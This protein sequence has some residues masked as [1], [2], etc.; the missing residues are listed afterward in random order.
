MASVPTSKIAGMVF[1]KL[2]ADKSNVTKTFCNA[3]MNAVLEVISDC[4]VAGDSVELK[5][6][7]VLKKKKKPAGTARKP[8]TGEVT[9]TEAKRVV[10]FSVSKTIKD[11]LNCIL[12]AVKK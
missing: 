8:R 4:L 2:T 7:G 12:A 9:P 6:V 11:K 1:D 10:K 3:T 5:G